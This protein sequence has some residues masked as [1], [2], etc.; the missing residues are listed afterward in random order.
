MSK[1]FLMLWMGWPGTIWKDDSN[2]PLLFE[3]NELVPYCRNLFAL[4]EYIPKKRTSNSKY[5]NNENL[6]CVYLIKASE[7]QKI[8]LTSDP[9][10]VNV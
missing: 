6:Y 10:F 9:E 4:P 3:L 2:V 1:N 7:P 8:T 5:P